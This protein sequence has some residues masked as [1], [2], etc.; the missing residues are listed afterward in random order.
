MKTEDFL[1]LDEGEKILWQGKPDASVLGV[2]LFTKGFAF[3]FAAAFLTFWSCGFFGGMW[4]VAT[5]QE[6]FNP[7]LTAGQVLKIVIP[8]CVL[9][10]F[11]YIAN[12]LKTYRYFVT[13]QRIVFIGGLLMKKRRS[14]HYHKVTD[15]EVSQNLFEQLLGIRSLKIF[16]AGTSSSMGPWGERAE[17]EFQGLKEADT[18][19]RLINTTLKSYRATGE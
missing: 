10:A 17:I 7:F 15:V 3:V 1:V 12:L 9:G 6:G 18:A 11:V 4:A 13:N 14:V 2:W 5:K 16:T 19:E 8:L